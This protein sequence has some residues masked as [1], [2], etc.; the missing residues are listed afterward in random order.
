MFVAFGREDLGESVSNWFSDVCSSWKKVVLKKKLQGR[1]K[2]P[3][4][5]IELGTSGMVDQSVTTR[6]PHHLSV[7]VNQGLCCGFESH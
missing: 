2:L 4:P 6:P 3:R 1:S 5:G 7:F